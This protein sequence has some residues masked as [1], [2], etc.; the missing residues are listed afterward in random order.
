MMA[1]HQSAA[2][3]AAYARHETEVYRQTVAAS[4]S[5]GPAGV[6]A[7]NIVPMAATA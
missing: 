6:V 5:I 2:A 4:W 1:V 7:A 3:H